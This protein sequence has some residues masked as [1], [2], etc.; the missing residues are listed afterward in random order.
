MPYWV[1]VRQDSCPMSYAAIACLSW[2][3]DSV[4]MS[5]GFSGLRVTAPIGVQLRVLRVQRLG[6]VAYAARYK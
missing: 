2:S 3:D 1:G 6:L 4:F 5:S